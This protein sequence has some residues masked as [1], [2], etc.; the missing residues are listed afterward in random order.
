M[1]KPHP[2]ENLIHDATES[3]KPEKGKDFGI[4][5]S[6]SPELEVVK[7]KLG[8][9][10]DAINHD[11]PLTLADIQNLEASLANMKVDVGGTMMTLAEIEAIPDLANNLKIWAEIQAG[12]FDNMEQLT[13]ITDEIAEHLA[14]HEGDLELDGLKSLSATAAKHLAKHRGYLFLVGIRH[15]SDTTI[16]QLS[17]YHGNIELGHLQ[18]LSDVAAEYFASH[19]GYL[20]LD[21]LTTLSDTAAEHL[22]KHKRDIGL[23]GLET[24]SDKAAEH[25]AKHEGDLGLQNNL[26]AQV[27]KFKK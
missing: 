2:S 1:E 7:E 9:V 8:I 22:A 26:R 17:T 25:L 3:G 15:L 6:L 18:E 11:Q 21:S 23:S 20:G 4:E 19:Q 16:E 27:N 24:L 12:N 10:E 13:F 5:L 14:T